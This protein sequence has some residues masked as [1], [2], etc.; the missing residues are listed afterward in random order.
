MPDTFQ[1]VAV[2]ALAL[3]PGAL[4]V[5]AFERQVGAWGAGFSDR[6]FRFVGFSAIM[7]AVAAP[8]TYPLW[9]EFV[10]SRRLVSG[11][12]PLALWLVPV[13]YV[14]VPTVLGTIVGV[15]TRSRR[16]WARIFTGPAPAPRAWDHLFA[17]RPDGWIRLR[18]KSGTWLGGAFAVLP[19]GSRSYAAG[20][21]DEQDLYLVEAVEVDPDGGE[22]VFDEQ[23]DP[24]SK[25]SAILI[26]WDEVEYL[27][28]IDA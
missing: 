19:D 14:V 26:R 24:V 20:Y 5:W 16:P 3:L 4:Y 22:F 21:P 12:V 7:H 10:V 9:L 17:A 15:A 27:D 13:A 8:L 25:G 18:L 1:G 6:V 28:F 11:D 23:G 2:L